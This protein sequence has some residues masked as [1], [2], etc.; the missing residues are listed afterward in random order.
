MS[1]RGIFFSLF[2][3]VTILGLNGRGVSQAQS[4]DP[5]RR[6]IDAPVI[7]ADL[8]YLEDAPE[9]RILLKL[10]RL[11]ANAYNRDQCVEPADLANLDA[12]ELYVKVPSKDQMKRWLEIRAGPVDRISEI[13]FQF[14]GS[15]GSLDPGEGAPEIESHQVAFPWDRS[16]NLGKMYKE[17]NRNSELGIGSEYTVLEFVFVPRIV[18]LSKQEASNESA[19]SDKLRIYPVS[20]VPSRFLDDR[21]GRRVTGDQEVSIELRSWKLELERAGVEF[22]EIILDDLQVFS[23]ENRLRISEYS[24]QEIRSFDLRLSQKL[25]TS[26]YSDPAELTR[27]N[28]MEFE[29][30]HR[31]Q[32]FWSTV[33]KRK[34]E[35]EGRGAN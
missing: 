17:L 24:A 3:A 15:T 8:S 10:K 11:A 13:E 2:A 21:Q 27:E 1:H 30:V 12:L 26:V 18:S 32:R 34:L 28:L 14:F 4:K 5:C 7:Q 29:Y 16:T 6:L 35:S 9:T 31:F 19:R 33:E 22:L 20:L 25:A 23:Q